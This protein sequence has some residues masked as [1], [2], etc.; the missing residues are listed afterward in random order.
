[1]NDRSDSP[2]DFEASAPIPINREFGMAFEF[3]WK[4]NPLFSWMFQNTGL[5]PE[6]ILP[7]DRKWDRGG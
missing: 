4:G 7:S 2:S 5:S 6:K 3:F 1:M